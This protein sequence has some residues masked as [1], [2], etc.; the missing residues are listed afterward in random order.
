MLARIALRGV[1]TTGNN[2]TFDQT[3]SVNIDG[4]QISRGNAL[5]V[6]QIDMNSIEILR[7]PQALFFGKNSPAGI[8]TIHTA[9][10]T[11]QFDAMVQATYDPVARRAS[12]GATL[13]PPPPP[14]F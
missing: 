9:D 14:W 8:V 4:V 3:V 7:G 13:S 12:G 11:D 6:G 1:G 2:P 5:R 10:P